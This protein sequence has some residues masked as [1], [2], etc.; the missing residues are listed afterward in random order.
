MTSQFWVHDD[1]GQ[2]RQVTPGRYVQETDLQALLAG[3]PEI[4]ANA[5]DA[6]QQELSM[7]L[8]AQELPIAFSDDEVS[9]TWSLD[10][11]FIDNH[12][13]PTLVEVKRSSDPRIRREVLG[14]LLEYAASFAT[15]WPVERLR[16]KLATDNRRSVGSDGVTVE[17]FVEAAEVFDGLE[18]FWSA[19]GDNLDA[20]RLRLMFVGDRLPSRLV[21]VIEYLNQQMSSTIVIG[22]EVTPYRV[23][24]DDN[25]HDA[26]VVTTKGVLAETLVAKQSGERRTRDEFDRVLA[27]RQGDDVLR[28]FTEFSEKLEHL[29]YWTSIGREKGN[30]QLYFNFTPPDGE[31]LW[32]LSIKPKTD[33]LA[34]Q[35]K[36]LQRHAAFASEDVRADYVERM[37]AAAGHPISEPNL[38]GFP[39]VPVSSL[40]SPEKL[41]ALVEAMRWCA[42]RAQE[43]DSPEV[44][45]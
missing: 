6:D 33:K 22:V 12:G 40:L 43:G 13:I 7:L 14:Q 2:M 17:E 23:G 44:K 32:P 38:V 3:R 29:G 30:P 31:P 1:D 5:I 42:L 28:A 16:E 27:D 19:V 37:G 34:L 24:G 20:G 8:V 41:D 21:R 9:T 11:L 4:L 36:R 10:H 35:L 45:Q 15:D 39:G 25:P 26:L 18:D